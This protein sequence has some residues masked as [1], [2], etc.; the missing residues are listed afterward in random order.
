MARGD[1]VACRRL[2]VAAVIGHADINETAATCARL[3]LAGT[4]A[5]K[6]PLV[7][8]RVEANR[9]CTD[10]KGG[11]PPI[12]DNRFAEGRPKYRRVEIEIVG[13]PSAVKKSSRSRC[14]IEPRAGRG[15]RVL[16]GDLRRADTIAIG[17]ATPVRR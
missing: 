15:A 7:G 1:G 6:K 11:R 12:A 16:A 3:S 13:T 8:N 14:R 5:V 17:S 9:I 10:A 4:D 2:E